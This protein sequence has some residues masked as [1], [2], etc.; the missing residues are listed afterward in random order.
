[1]VNVAR[2]LKTDESYVLAS[3]AEQ[4]YYVKDIKD[5]NWQVLVK[6][7]PRDLYD[8][9][10]EEAGEEPCQENEELGSRLHESNLEEDDDNMVPLDRSE[11]ANTNVE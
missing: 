10:I 2:R 7:K 3:Q 5:S 1:M 11:L 9:P 8:F 4:V 6:T